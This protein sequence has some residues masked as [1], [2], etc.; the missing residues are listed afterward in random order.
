MEANLGS[1]WKFEAVLPDGVSVA[2]ARVGVWMKSVPVGEIYEFKNLKLAPG[3]V[4]VCR[5]M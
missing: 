2:R 4:C 1:V 3:C 5:T